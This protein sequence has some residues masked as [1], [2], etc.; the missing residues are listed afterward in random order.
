MSNHQR[1]SMSKAGVPI[2]A[3][4]AGMRRL[5]KALK[6][7]PKDVQREFRTNWRKAAKLVADDAKSR[8]SYSTRI[9]ATIKIRGTGVNIKIVAGGSAAPNAAPLEMGN[10]GSS[11]NRHPVFAPIGSNAYQNPKRWVNQP[12]R[13]FLAP[14]LEAHK[15]EVMAMMEDAITSAV[16]KAIGE[17]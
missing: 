12:T 9:P 10:R 6:L 11:T 4:V 16:N 15:G 2:V 17:K 1:P 3:D 8:A 13:P 7:A 14:A 5:A